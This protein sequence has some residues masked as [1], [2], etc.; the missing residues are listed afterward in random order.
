M[1]FRPGYFLIVNQNGLL[2]LKLHLTMEKKK[3]F[4]F[5]VQSAFSTNPPHNKLYVSS[6][7]KFDS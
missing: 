1:Q 4:G 3:L 5:I 7:F 6:I 2:N